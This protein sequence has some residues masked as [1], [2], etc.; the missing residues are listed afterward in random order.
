MYLDAKGLITQKG[1]DGGDTLQREGF[2]YEGCALLPI[3]TKFSSPGMATYPEALNIL[4][5]PQG[6]VRSWQSPYNNPSD[7]SRDQLV[8]N[9]RALGYLRPPY[10]F[11]SKIFRGVVKNYSRF[12]NGDIAFIGDYARFIR[13][14]GLWYLYPI[15]FVGDLVLVVNALLICF[16][17]AR[18]PNKW[19]T[20]LASKVSWLYWLTNQ[21]PPNAE[22]V[23]QS[24]YGPTNTSNDINFIGDLAQAQHVYSTPIS[25]IA[26]KLYTAFRPN[27]I[28]YALNN[29][30]SAASGAD[31]EFAS[32]WQI[33]VER[34]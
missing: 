24:P 12:P 1:G 2:W 14:F 9:I 26:R 21:Y 7:T 23:P 15:L 28:Q 18:I 20:W 25:F 8:S 13:A 11:L 27:G 3:G 17:L 33:T 10:P 30:F 6:F 22:G 34:F 16:W 4:Q 19:Q 29:Y 5:T 32:L 31:T